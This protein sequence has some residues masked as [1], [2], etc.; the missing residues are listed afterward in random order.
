[1]DLDADLGTY[2]DGVER[3][4]ELHARMKLRDILTH[5]AGLK[6]WVPFYKRLLDKGEWRP[7]MFGQGGRGAP[8]AWRNRCMRADTVTA[9]TW[10]LDLRR[11]AGTGSTC[12]QRHG[13]DASCG[14]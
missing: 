12:V 4:H 2:L 14:G 10:L 9:C 6:A 11:W 5:Q 13:Q 8:C 1:M 3:K 7:G